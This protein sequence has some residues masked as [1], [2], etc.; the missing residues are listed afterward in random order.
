[1]D[2]EIS[3]AWE[4]R[5]AAAARRGRSQLDLPASQSNRR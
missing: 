3:I 2:S 4:F 1:M 5:S